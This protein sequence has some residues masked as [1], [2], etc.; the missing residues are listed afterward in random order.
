MNQAVSDRCYHHIDEPYTHLFHASLLF[1]L[2]P[3]TNENVFDVENKEF[4]FTWYISMIGTNL[5]H[6]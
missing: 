1:Q 3:L 4:D 2:R 5:F 6:W